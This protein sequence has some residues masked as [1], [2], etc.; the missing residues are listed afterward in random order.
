MTARNFREEIK[1]YNSCCLLDMLLN[2]LQLKLKKFRTDPSNKSNKFSFQKL[3][4]KSFLIHKEAD[5]R[6]ENTIQ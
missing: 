3:L 2:S 5:L 1:T 4:R 6:S